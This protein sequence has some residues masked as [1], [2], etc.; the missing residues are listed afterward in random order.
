MEAFYICISVWLGGERGLIRGKL[1]PK[2]RETLTR[3]RDAAD[4]AQAA[5]PAVQY[6]IE[7]F[8]LKSDPNAMTL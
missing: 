5:A 2:T 1:V 3:K 4:K 8:D 7:V 6:F